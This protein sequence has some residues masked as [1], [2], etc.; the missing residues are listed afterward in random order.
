MI[1]IKGDGLYERTEI[2]GIDQFQAVISYFRHLNFLRSMPL[3]QLRLDGCFG[4]LA[5]T[6]MFLASLAKF[7]S[8]AIYIAIMHSMFAQ[9]FFCSSGLSYHTRGQAR[10]Q[11]VQKKL[12]VA[13]SNF[14]IEEQIKELQRLV[15]R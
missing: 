5:T 3:A 15:V 14:E 7:R 9:S 8:S 2:Y 13:V 11:F 12:H 10:L 6:R 4:P 1:G